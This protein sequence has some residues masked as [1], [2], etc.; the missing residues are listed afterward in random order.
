MNTAPG[1]LAGFQINAQMSSNVVP[2]NAVPVQVTIGGVISQDGV[3]L[4]V[5][6]APAQ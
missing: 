2:G 5:H 4:A 6:E 3:T 1:Y